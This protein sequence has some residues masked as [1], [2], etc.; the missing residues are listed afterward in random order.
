[1]IRIVLVQRW[2]HH[3][4]TTPK[5]A[6]KDKYPLLHVEDE[7][8]YIAYDKGMSFYGNYFLGHVI[9]PT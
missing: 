5:Y 9:D 7:E 4:Q 3:K 6:P 1:M 8:F 2:N